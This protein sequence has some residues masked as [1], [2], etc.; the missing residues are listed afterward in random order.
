MQN[1]NLDPDFN[2]IFGIAEEFMSPEHRLLTHVLYTAV[3][4]AFHSEAHIRRDAMAWFESTRRARTK[5]QEFMRFQNV[6]Q[7]L[8]LSQPTVMAILDFV[9]NRR[10]HRVFFRLVEG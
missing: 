8:G 10:N 7:E 4:D 9:H 1:V 3:K 6:V 5:K 2:A